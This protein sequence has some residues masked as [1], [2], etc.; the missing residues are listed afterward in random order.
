MD[1][2]ALNKAVMEAV[3]ASGKAF[4]TQTTLDGAFW[5]RAIVFHAG[6]TEADLTA[7]IEVVLAE[8]ARLNA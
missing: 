6:T 4:I 7:L 8:A 5:L 2:D 1:S 3:Q